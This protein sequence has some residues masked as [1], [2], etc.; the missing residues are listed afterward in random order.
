MAGTMILD[1]VFPSGTKPIASGTTNAGATAIPSYQITSYNDANLSDH[2]YNDPWIDTWGNVYFVD[3]NGYLNAVP[4]VG[5]GGVA[6][7]QT[8]LIRPM[9]EAT[10]NQRVKLYFTY[11][12]GGAGFSLMLRANGDNKSCVDMRLNSDGTF[13]GYSVKDNWVNNSGPNTGNWTPPADNTPC[14]FTATA[15]TKYSIGKIIPTSIGSGYTTAPTVTISGDGTGAT[16]TAIVGTEH[17]TSDQ[18]IGYTITSG[19]SGYTYATIT[20]TPVGDDKGSGATA[21]VVLSDPISTFSADI[22][23]QADPT[24]SL[25]FCSRDDANIDYQYPGSIGFNNFYSSLAN[26]SITRI[27]YESLDPKLPLKPSMPTILGDSNNNIISISWTGGVPPVKASLYEKKNSLLEYDIANYT[28]VGE[29]SLPGSISRPAPASGT[30]DSIRWAFTTG[31]GSYAVSPLGGIPNGGT[32]NSIYAMGVV[33]FKDPIFIFFIGDSITAGSQYAVGEHSVQTRVACDYIQNTMAP[34]S[35]YGYNRGVSGSRSDQWIKGQGNY[36]SLMTLI[37][38]QSSKFMPSSELIIHIMIGT[39]DAQNGIDPAIFKTNL[40]SIISDLDSDIASSG[41]TIN[42]KFIISHIPFN[43]IINY[44]QATL[45]INSQIT[46]LTYGGNI[47]K[48]A[49][50]N[51]VYTMTQSNPQGYTSDYLGF[52]SFSGLNLPANDAVHVGTREDQRLYS[53]QRSLGSVWGKSIYQALNT[54]GGVSNIG[55]MIKI[56]FH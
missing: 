43:Y 15:I 36:S 56:R 18:I 20:I 17:I 51:E 35:V 25:G 3:S 50:F 28:K 22:A 34:I 27:T 53:G 48:G 39:N 38:D 5:E 12:T 4:T 23:T 19:G 54:G 6:F 42:P 49:S 14:V 8:R 31:D 37:N 40:M 44:N 55:G 16:A 7:F 45:D 11:K 32:S 21:T 52:I 41:I 24:T 1:Q 47:Y 10:L 46:N 33:K 30:Q 9:S 29:I 2:A 13:S 26:D